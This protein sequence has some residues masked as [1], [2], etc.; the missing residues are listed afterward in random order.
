VN[1]IGI[2]STSKVLKGSA[3]AMQHYSGG[4]RPSI[5]G[6]P[7]SAARAVAECPPL[8]RRG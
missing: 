2:G 7:G 6:V 1:R 4:L 8:M 3:T 5:V